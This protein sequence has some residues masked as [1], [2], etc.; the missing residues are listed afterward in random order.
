[1]HGL[2][3]ARSTTLGTALHLAE[4]PLPIVFGHVWAFAKEVAGEAIDAALGEL[5]N[6]Q[7]GQAVSSHPLQHVRTSSWHLLQVC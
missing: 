5:Q 3:A 4:D 2:L 1:M 6:C 7:V